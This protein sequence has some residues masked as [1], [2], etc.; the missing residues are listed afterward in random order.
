MPGRFHRS[1]SVTIYLKTIHVNFTDRSPTDQIKSAKMLT[2]ESFGSH[3]V[4]AFWTINNVMLFKT[5]LVFWKRLDDEK[6]SR[7][8]FRLSLLYWQYYRPLVLVFDLSLFVA[9]PLTMIIQFSDV[10]IDGLLQNCSNS[11]A[12]STEL[13]QSSTNT[14]KIKSSNGRLVKPVPKAY[15][16]KSSKTRH[17]NESSNDYFNFVL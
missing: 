15:T 2:F 8:K 13:Q 16:P 11:S 7:F 9:K 5:W 12:L 10:Y 17:L 1:Y 14:Q 6:K 3:W 4:L